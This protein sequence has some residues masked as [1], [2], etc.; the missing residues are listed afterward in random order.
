[1]EFSAG[2]RSDFHEPD[3]QNIKFVGVVGTSLDNAFGDYVSEEH[4][5]K[6]FQEV[7]VFFEKDRKQ[8]K[9]NLANLLAL[10]KAGVSQMT[11]YVVK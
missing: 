11:R 9:F 1:M 2:T 6:G 5:A 7:V 10:T 3:E 4:I 8:Y